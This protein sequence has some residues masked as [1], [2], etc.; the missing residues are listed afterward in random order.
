LT[1]HPW[2]KIRKETERKEERISCPQH[3][4]VDRGLGKEGE[5]KK[6]KNTIFFSIA[7]R[8]QREEKNQPEEKKKR[9]KPEEGGEGGRGTVCLFPP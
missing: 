4:L 5:G 9:G 3:G 1:N 2:T 8:D 7:E 6:K